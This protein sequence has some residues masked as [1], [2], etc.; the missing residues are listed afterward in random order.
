MQFAIVKNVRFVALFAVTASSL[1]LQGAT[2][3]FRVL[4][5]LADAA[6]ESYNRA[7][8]DWARNTLERINPTFPRC[9]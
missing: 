1:A 3:D 5:R 7:V 2:G 9:F 6:I 8:S 4:V